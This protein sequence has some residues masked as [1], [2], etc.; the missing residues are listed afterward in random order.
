MTAAPSL[1][2]TVAMS[3]AAAYVGGML[4]RL[5]RLPPLVPRSPRALAEGW[6]D[7]YR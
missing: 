1:I 2:A 5:V 7:R 4:A 3:L 6:S